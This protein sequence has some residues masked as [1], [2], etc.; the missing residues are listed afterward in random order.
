MQ[1]GQDLHAEVVQ[2]EFGKVDFGVEE[3]CFDQGQDVDVPAV[4]VPHNQV[5]FLIVL[6]VS[7][8]GQQALY[9]PFNDFL[10]LQ[11]LRHQFL[12]QLLTLLS[13]LKVN[14]HVGHQQLEQLEGEAF[15]GGIF[16]ERGGETG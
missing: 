5:Q 16:T 2:A 6:N 4:Q 10:I 15:L 12:A 8:V 9:H 11:V 1:P 14:V 3:L 13:V 7:R